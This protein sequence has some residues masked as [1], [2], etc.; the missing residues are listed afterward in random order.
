MTRRPKREGKYSLSCRDEDW[1]RLKAR[2]SHAGSTSV[3]A[4]IVE[5]AL[6][7]DPT[8][9]RMDAALAMEHQETITQAAR[10]LIAHLP[11]VPPEKATPLWKTLHGRISFL[12]R[13]AMDD[14]LDQGRR[15]ALE[16]HLDRQFGAGSGARMVSAYLERTGRDDI[17]E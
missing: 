13:M 10:R 14:M 8:R 17:P 15:S 16:H 7:V 3:S 6:A 5:T 12:V 9:P 11:P 4:F 2:A 1:E